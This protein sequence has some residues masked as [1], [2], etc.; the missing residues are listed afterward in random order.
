MFR[1]TLI[2][3][4]IAL[5][6]VNGLAG[7]CDGELAVT[8]VYSSARPGPLD[9]AYRAYYVKRF[10]IQVHAE[11]DT[12]LAYLSKS[13]LNENLQSAFSQRPLLILNHPIDV[14]Q[15]ESFLDQNP[16]ATVV[17]FRSGISTQSIFSELRD[18]RILE[19]THFDPSEFSPENAPAESAYLVFGAPTK[20]ARL[21]E[22][23]QEGSQFFGLELSKSYVKFFETFPNQVLSRQFWA[24]HPSQPVLDDPFKIA[25]G[26][27]DRDLKKTLDLG[28]GQPAVQTPAN[29]GHAGATLEQAT[30]EVRSWYKNQYGIKKANQPKSFS[31]H[32]AQ[33]ASSA[34]GQVF[35]GLRPGSKVAIPSPSYYVYHT[36]ARAQGLQIALYDPLELA[37]QGP[38]AV[39]SQETDL[40]MI[41]TNFPHN[42]TGK[43]LTQTLANE[44]QSFAAR[45]TWVVNDLSYPVLAYDGKKVRSILHGAKSL[46]NLIEVLGASKDLGLPEERISAVVGDPI[47]ISRLQDYGQGETLE[48]SKRR[49][50]AMTERLKMLNPTEQEKLKKEFQSRR[51]QIVQAFLEVGW[52]KS[53][54][55]VPEGGMNIVLE[56]PESMSPNELTTEL[57]QRAGI[58]VSPGYFLDSNFRSK[59]RFVRVTFSETAERIG[60]LRN[61]LRQS[62]FRYPN[63]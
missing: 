46:K 50:G 31:V 8:Q 32:F 26:F 53:K 40:K 28:S 47:L 48:I 37:N 10:G 41:L 16:E 17:V 36:L 1:S 5:L 3:F 61:L 7:I 22:A 62:G 9:P 38:T 59:R 39:F 52:P 34:L 55:T 35:A 18:E 44:L 60:N 63:P 29:L 4:A 42:P 25:P 20:I 13:N 56:V 15:A 54:M 23:K 19:V 6:P 27:R 12:T 45:G 51:D 58:Y 2:L 57:W 11:T 30:A 21:L 33:G 49:L 14:A 24:P 43:L